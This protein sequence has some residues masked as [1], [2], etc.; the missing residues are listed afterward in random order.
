MFFSYFICLFVVIAEYC[1]DAVVVGGFRRADAARCGFDL[2]VVVEDV[3]DSEVEAIA[4]VCV[5]VAETGIGVGVAVVFFSRKV[6]VG[7]G[8]VVEVAAD[9]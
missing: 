6:G 8:R 7:V 4:V 9:E 2:P 3:V 1:G 5:S